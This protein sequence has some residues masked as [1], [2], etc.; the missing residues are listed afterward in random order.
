MGS[1][2]V[3]AKVVQIKL[4]SLLDLIL[5]DRK[6]TEIEWQASQE[7]LSQKVGTPFL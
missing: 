3:V 2:A 7:N 1:L 6:V 4:P 5:F